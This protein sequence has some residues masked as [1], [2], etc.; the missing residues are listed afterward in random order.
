MSSSLFATLLVLQ[1]FNVC[2]YSL[3]VNGV[4]GKSVLLPTKEER[5]LKGI[6]DMNW[7]KNSDDIITLV[8]K[9]ENSPFEIQHMDSNFT[10]RLIVNNDTGALNISN[11]REEDSGE[12]VFGGLISSRSLKPVTYKLQVYERIVSVQVTTQVNNST[13]SCN[14]TLSCSVFGSHQVALFWSTNGGN[15]PGTENKTTLTVSPTLA[16]EIYTCTAKNPVSSQ[17]SSVTV[18][19]CQPRAPSPGFSPCALKS[20]LFS[21]GLVAMVSAVIAVNVRERCCSDCHFVPSGTSPSPHLHFTLR[22]AVCPG[23]TVVE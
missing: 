6:G 5:L 4:V 15:I 7:K 8:R 1:V 21:T 18:K 19:S 22:T 20:V 10:G 23:A 14:V 11:L 9:S 17:N 16:E 13:D 3:Q 2:G 12:Y